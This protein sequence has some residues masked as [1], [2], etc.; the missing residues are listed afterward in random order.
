MKTKLVLFLLAVAISVTAQP[1]DEVKTTSGNRKSFIGY[2]IEP[3]CQFGKI[4]G[5]NAINPGIG[6][7]LIFNNGM[8]LGVKYK[9]ILTEN[10]PVGEDNKL[11]LDGKWGGIRFEY[12]INADKVVNLSFPFEAGIGEIELDIKDSFENQQAIIP[13]EDAWFANIETGVALEIKVWKYVKLNLA[14][15]YRFVSNVSF[16]S[17]SQKDLMGFNYS[18]G[19][20]IGIFRTP[21][22][23]K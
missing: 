7:G 9:Y 20:K 8:S 6:A 10:T 21:E 15:G 19:L 2:F 11:Y 18:A 5:T 3:S 22:K 14:A 12:A 17:L 13:S 1:A 23:R 4:A 16:R